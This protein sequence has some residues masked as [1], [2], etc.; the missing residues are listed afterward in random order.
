[1]SIIMLLLLTLLSI[2]CTYWIAKRRHADVRFWIMMAL[3]F[4]PLALPF[5]LFA[6]SKK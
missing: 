4:G 2:G 6:R 1:M 3:L 5:V